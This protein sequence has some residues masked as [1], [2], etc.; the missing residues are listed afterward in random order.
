MAYQVFSSSITP[1]TDT[2][3][4]NIAPDL[5]HCFAGIRYLDSNGDYITPTG[6]SVQ[7]QAKHLTN[8]MYE[9]AVNADLLATEPQEAEWSGNV[10]SVK[11][12]P[13]SLAGADLVSYQ[14]VV[15]QNVS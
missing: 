11:A 2:I 9:N 4:L 15:V 10:T 8:N 7:I 3:E 1:L 13:S 6:G 14:L 12:T 5:A